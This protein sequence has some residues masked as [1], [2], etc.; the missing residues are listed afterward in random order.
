MFGL[1][2]FILAGAIRVI[3]ITVV[4]FDAVKKIVP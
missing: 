4:I 2:T 3:T 1:I